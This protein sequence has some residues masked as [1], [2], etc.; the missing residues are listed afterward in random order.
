MQ[1]SGRRARRS[2]P[3]PKLITLEEWLALPGTDYSHVCMTKTV[4]W[5]SIWWGRF[6]EERCSNLFFKRAWWS[7]RP[8]QPA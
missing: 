8:T 4:S 2:K 1:K 6:L 3:T 7:L 5:S